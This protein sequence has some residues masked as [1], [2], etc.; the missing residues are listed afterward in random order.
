MSQFCGAG[1]EGQVYPSWQAKQDAQESI[2][3]VWPADPKQV[4]QPCG[5]N[6]IREAQEALSVNTQ[7]IQSRW[8][9]TT[10]MLNHKCN[11]AMCSA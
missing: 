1:S 5:W 9:C 11:S 8:I 4:R 10:V 6:W 3:P 7:A 2:L